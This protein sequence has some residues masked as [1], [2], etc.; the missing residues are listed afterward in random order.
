[1]TSMTTL[2]WLQRPIHMHVDSGP[3]SLDAPV[4]I[5]AAGDRVAWTSETRRTVRMNE[6]ATETELV[7]LFMPEAVEAMRFDESALVMLGT[8]AIHRWSP[9]GGL[10][11]MGDRPSPEGRLSRTGRW[12]LFEAN[13]SLLRIDT[14]DGSSR[15]LVSKCR[16]R[17]VDLAISDDGEVVAR[18]T[19]KSIRVHRAG[20]SDVQQLSVDKGPAGKGMSFSPD[21][22]ALAVGAGDAL[23]HCYVY[24][25]NRPEKPRFYRDHFDPL[26]LADGILSCQGWHSEGCVLHIAP[27]GGS[28]LT[29][30][31]M[32]A[33]CRSYSHDGAR[34]AVNTSYLGSQRVQV[35]EIPSGEPITGKAGEAY[36]AVAVGDH[37]VVVDVNGRVTRF[38]EQGRACRST[39]HPGLTSAFT[40]TADGTRAVYGGA[41]GVAML[42]LAT[43]E[44]RWHE[45]SLGRVGG[46]RFLSSGELLAIVDSSG[47][48]RSLCRLDP[49]SGARVAQWS[50]P[51]W[52]DAMF[53]RPVG[54]GWVSVAGRKGVVVLDADA[55]PIIEWKVPPGGYLAD[56]DEDG[57]HALVSSEGVEVRLWDTCRSEVVASL[58]ASNGVRRDLGFARSWIVGAANTGETV[59]GYV[60]SRT[61]A[62]VQ[63]IAWPV[64]KSAGFIVQPSQ[65]FLTSPTGV[66]VRYDPS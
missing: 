10:A 44:L 29:G 36:S 8:T 39:R 41:G 5:S 9:D 33:H 59:S 34:L 56:I 1:M 38:D 2:E 47:P 28:R 61:G 26:Y 31:K 46:C 20:A 7:R 66:V 64:V 32:T 50:L 60:W 24:D 65:V 58:D 13:G 17:A 25:L 15:T 30:V 12:A 21:A 23:Y 18:A 14:R 3:L 19:A 42:D 53:V 40:A 22:R 11:R 16:G 49:D 43:L 48:G 63:R 54:L 4:C 35:L 57:R 62:L 52:I 55:R 37:T 6:V 45:A 51:E 27:S